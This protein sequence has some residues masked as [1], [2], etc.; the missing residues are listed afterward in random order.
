MPVRASPF[1]CLRLAFALALAPLLAA[2]A[3]LLAPAA[4]AAGHTA[5]GGLIELAPHSR[6]IVQGPQDEA[7]TQATAR[8]LLAGPMQR[9]EALASEQR[10]EGGDRILWVRTELPALGEGRVWHLRLPEVR[11]DRITLYRM[12]ADGALVVEQAG[13]AVPASQWAERSRMPRFRLGTADAAPA[14]VVLRVQHSG[15]FWLDLAAVDD[16]RLLHDEQQAMLVIALYLGVMGFA[17]VYS[18]CSSPSRAT[19]STDCMRPTRR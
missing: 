17:I 7:A 13:E 8:A 4:Q 2:A 12:D 1:R 15:S 14:A 5:D 10:Q 9:G 16:E 18:W 19:G 6:T 3:V 11:L